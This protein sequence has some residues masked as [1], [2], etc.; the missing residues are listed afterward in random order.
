MHSL[1]KSLSET[2]I[3]S[4]YNYCR[5]LHKSAQKGELNKFELLKFLSNFNAFFFAKCSSL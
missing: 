1:R 2:C 5:F 3:T 4:L